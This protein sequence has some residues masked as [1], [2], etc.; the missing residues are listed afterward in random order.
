MVHEHNDS[1]Q[2]PPLSRARCSDRANCSELQE[3][4]RQLDRLQIRILRLLSTTPLKWEAEFKL[5]R[6][7][8]RLNSRQ[9][10]LTRL[11]RGL[12]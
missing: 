2:R 4:V 5:R 8:L 3:A 9:L 1:A 11:M 7:L 12:A 6:R 10:E